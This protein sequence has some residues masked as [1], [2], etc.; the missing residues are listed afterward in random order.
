MM[1]RMA[2]TS[3][4]M[5]WTVMWEMT[6]LRK[7]S[8]SSRKVVCANRLTTLLETGKGGAFPPRLRASGLVCTLV[9]KSGTGN[10]VKN[11]N[12]LLVR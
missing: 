2:A 9:Y 7:E 6:L 5:S 3:V 8:T 12:N 10:L 4:V 1:R 11:G